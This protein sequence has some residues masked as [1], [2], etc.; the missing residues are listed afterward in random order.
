MRTWQLHAG[1]PLSLNLAADARLGTVDYTNDQIWALQLSGGSPPALALNTSYGLRAREMR[2]FPAFALDDGPS[3]ADVEQFAQAPVLEQCFVNYARVVCS[4]VAHIAAICEFWVPDSHTVAGRITL[5][6]HDDEE[7]S[8]QLGV[9]AV[10]RP[11]ANGTPMRWGRDGA[12]HYLHGKSGL[13]FPVVHLEGGRPVET[14]PWATLGL[15][16]PLNPGESRR[17]R[18]V[19]AAH[20]GAT[21]SFEATL[22]WLSEDWRPALRRV[23]AINERLV[24]IHT[25]DPE[26]DAAL[27]MSQRVALASFVGPTGALPH[28]SPVVARTIDRGFSQLGNGSDYGWQWNGQSAMLLVPLALHLRDVAPD[29][30]RGTIRNALA[31]QQADGSIDWKPGLAGQR[32]NMLSLPLLATV[33]WWVHDAAPD[34]EFLAEVYSGLGR[35]VRHWLDGKNDFDEDHLPEWRNTMQSGFDHNPVFCRWHNWAQ[36]A[37]I[38]AT[39]APDL[40]SYLYS[41]C[42]ALAHMA[43]ALEL[44]DDARYW[45]GQLAELGEAAQ[46]MYD[47]ASGQYRYID[48][49]T[50]HT[51]A[52]LVLGSGPGNITIEVFEAFD[53]PQRVLVRVQ[54][55]DGQ[56]A[57][58]VAVSI[59]GEGTRGRRVQVLKGRDF[60]WYWGFGTATGDKLYTAIKRV[61]VT[62]LNDECE[63]WVGTVDLTAADLTHFMPL[64]AGMVSDEQRDAIIERL[65]DHHRFWRPF[66]TALV[67]ADS[68]VYSPATNDGVGAVWPFWTWLLIDG[69]VSQSR[70]YLAADLL[71]R[72][73]QS[74]IHTLKTESN[75]RGQ[76]H[77]DKREGLGERDHVAGAVPVS[78]FLRV[79]GVR[80]LPDKRV[81]LRGGNPFPNPI[82]IHHRGL[83]VVKGHE[84]TTI[85]YPDGRSWVVPHSPDVQIVGED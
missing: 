20:A 1:D 50:H 26:W 7:H 78:L 76:Y 13:L 22:K 48:R 43:R 85:S 15:H 63:V 70:T 51:P 62:G 83:T 23:A 57:S 9:S 69:L 46:R 21:L 11:Q 59:H 65:L 52:G 42:R 34:L 45:A 16:V 72:V 77:P 61:E 68:P 64:W 58:E 17:V 24:D 30:L 53:V 60:S 54:C 71:T 55:P 12:R 66:G 38:N 56:Q 19:S 49:D 81:E 75:F 3:V 67:P 37:D 27:Y 41:E 5:T 32:H 35:F 14:S 74:I 47:P 2:I 29:L 39:E 4:P 18:W 82:T 25:G 80:V 8:V 33:A 73:M 44:P 36:G 79:L 28:P 31:V 10:L 84:E 40:A 6:N